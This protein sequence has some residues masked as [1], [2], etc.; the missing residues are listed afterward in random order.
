M[1]PGGL[2]FVDTSEKNREDKSGDHR[3]DRD[4]CER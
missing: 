3:E 4:R 2:V 1:N